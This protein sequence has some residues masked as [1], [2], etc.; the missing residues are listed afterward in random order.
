MDIQLWKK[1]KKELKL[2][3][4]QLAEKSGISRRTIAGIFSGDPTYQSPTLN[5]IEAIERALGLYTSPQIKK[6]HVIKDEVEIDDMYPIPLLGRVVAGKPISEQE[7]LEGYIYVK[8]RPKEEYFAVH[9]YGDSMINAGI[10][11]GSIIVCHKQETA[12][13]GDIVVAMLN[14]EQTVKRFKLI[15]DTCFLMPENPRYDP[16]PVTKDD[17]LLILGKVVEMRYSF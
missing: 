7:D 16:I 3:H 17:E 9:V 2:T 4:D 5:T 10:L 11:D 12:E 15:G 6:D 13:S 14:G 1:R 8:Y